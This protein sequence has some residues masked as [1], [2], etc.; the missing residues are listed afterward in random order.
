MIIALG[1]ALPSFAMS[2]KLFQV[3]RAPLMVDEGRWVNGGINVFAS[4]F[5]LLHGGAFLGGML[6]VYSPEKWLSFLGMFGFY[7]LVMSAIS[8]GFKSPV[9]LRLFASLAIG[10]GVSLLF[11]TGSQDMRFLVIHG[12]VCFGL[13]LVMV[14]VSVA[15]PFPRLGI[16]REIA[17]RFREPGTGGLW[18]ELPHRAIA[19]AAFYYLVLGVLE[20]LMFTGTDPA[21][22]LPI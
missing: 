1:V 8:A 21:V 4:E 10:R 9:L 17:A 15:V 3:W 22:F 14:V 13:Y 2:A 5:I 11:G 19:A 7:A 12:F 6:A 18:Y 20:L 16:T